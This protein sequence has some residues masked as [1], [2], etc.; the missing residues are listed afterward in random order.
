MPKPPS[1]PLSLTAGAT[2]PYDAV[3]EADPMYQKAIV[4]QSKKRQPKVSK[5]LLARGYSTGWFSDDI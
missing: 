2:C 5:R 1:L 3:I 4:P